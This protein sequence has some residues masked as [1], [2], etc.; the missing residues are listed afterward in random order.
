MH[1]DT[2]YSQEPAPESRTAAV[3]LHYPCFDGVVSAAMAVDFLQRSKGWTFTSYSPV[4]YGQKSTWLQTP[5]S[6]RSA[7]VDFLYHPQ[8]AFWADHHATT[9]LTEQSAEEYRSVTPHGNRTLLYDRRAT[10]CAILL[11]RTIGDQLS[12]RARYAEMATWAD[13]I[14]SA[15]YATVEEAIY[16]NS[17]AG[18]INDSLS[19]DA[20]NQAYCE[21]LLSSMLSMPLQAV[22]DLPEV[23]RRASVT[24]RRVTAGL[25][26]VKGSIR[27][28]DGEIAVFTAN[29][30]KNSTINR[31]SPYL[32]YGHAAYSV[33]LVR[34][35]GS[36]KITAMRNPWRQF[37]SI[38]LGKIFEKY[39]GGG[40]QRVAS[41][42]IP[43][44]SGRDPQQV[45]GEV[46]SDVK[47]AALHSATI[48]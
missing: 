45:L 28:D 15:N 10:S 30:T 18:L 34:S 46:V 13:K 39:G 21:L 3:Y 35:N 48:P 32:Y 9:F 25:K 27:L 20:D 19:V 2:L 14:D 22:S 44:G 42:V 33:G 40:H 38:E 41:L 31:Y 4:N 47:Q 7:V 8:A 24:R 29:E 26:A 23:R 5:L 12:D 11:L 17:A 36:W 6:E 43:A 37:E 1:S 16:G